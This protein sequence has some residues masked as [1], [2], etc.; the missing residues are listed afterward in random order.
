MLT[1]YLPKLDIT[2]VRNMQRVGPLGVCMLLGRE[3]VRNVQSTR[4]ICVLFR[5]W[6]V[7]HPLWLLC[8]LFDGVCNT[9]S[10]ILMPLMLLKILSDSS[11]LL[12]HASHDSV[13][14]MRRERSGTLWQGPTHLG[15][16]HSHFHVL[17][18]FVGEIMG[19]HW[20]VLSWRRNDLGKIKLFLLFSP[21]HPIY[22][23]A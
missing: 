14:W 12:P 11:R 19:W 18:S 21:V 9:V 2:V 10:R 3:E 7:S 22:I 6:Q 4:D 5:D 13:P 8:R 23:S 16:P 17:F 1:S 20:A 15:K